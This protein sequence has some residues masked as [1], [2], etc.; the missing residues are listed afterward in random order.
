MWRFVLCAKKF[1]LLKKP[2][3]GRFFNFK[4]ENMS[5]YSAEKAEQRGE[6]TIGI[7]RRLKGETPKV[8]RYLQ[9]RGKVTRTCKGGHY[10]VDKNLAKGL[11]LNTE[12]EPEI[13]RTLTDEHR[14]GHENDLMIPVGNFLFRLHVT[15]ASLCRLTEDV[16]ER[17]GCI[18]TVMPIAMSHAEQMGSQI[19]QSDV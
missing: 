7:T 13:S 8:L 16:D 17:A 15:N 2:P 14:T 6:L 19:G 18:E 1:R 10:W 3:L 5:R 11:M 9:L 4:G 12:S